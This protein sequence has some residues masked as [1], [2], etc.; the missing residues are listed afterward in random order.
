MA[1]DSVCVLLSIFARGASLYFPEYFCKIAG[2]FKAA[3]GADV[4]GFFLGHAQKLRS[5]LDAELS[6][7]LYGSCA[8]CGVKAAQ[9]F[10]FAY[11]CAFGNQGSSKLLGIMAV[12]KLKHDFNPLCVSQPAFGEGAL[13]TGA[14]LF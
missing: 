6:H 4:S 7:I 10:A 2:V 11:H 13:K 5:L 12:D 3:F 8:D 1:L 14:M 9:A